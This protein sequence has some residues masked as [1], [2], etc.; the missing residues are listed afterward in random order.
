M[1]IFFLSEGIVRLGEGFSQVARKK[2]LRG[3]CGAVRGGGYRP[4]AVIL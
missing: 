3:D 2:I 4:M 1:G